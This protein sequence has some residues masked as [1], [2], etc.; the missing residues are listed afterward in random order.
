MGPRNDRCRQGHQQAVRIGVARPDFAY[1]VSNQQALQ[2]IGQFVSYL[3][4]YKKQR[5]E[6]ALSK[7][8]ALTP[9]NGKY[10]AEIHAERERFESAFL[11]M[12]ARSDA[13]H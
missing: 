9:R 12:T 11:A 2:L 10:S 13:G 8:S 7:Y 4:S 1:S 6:L 3:R 5:A